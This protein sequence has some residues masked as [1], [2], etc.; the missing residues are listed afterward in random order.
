VKFEKGDLGLAL[1]VKVTTL[2]DTLSEVELMFIYS[3]LRLL[4]HSKKK[5]VID[6]QLQNLLLLQLI[7]SKGSSW[8]V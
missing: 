4:F 3:T 5:I 6:V 8:L 2:V 1:Q 7:H